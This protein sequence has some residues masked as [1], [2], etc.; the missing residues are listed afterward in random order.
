MTSARRLCPF[1]SA[2]DYQLG[3]GLP[4][5]FGSFLYTQALL[6]GDKRGFLLPGL[7]GARN[8]PG[9]PKHSCGMGGG[10]AEHKLMAKS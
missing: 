6:L 8:G 3:F 1:L 7:F 10:R 2:S 9:Q 5:G 4:S